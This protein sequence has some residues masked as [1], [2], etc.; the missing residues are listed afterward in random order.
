MAAPDT[1]A[2]DTLPKHAV[3]AAITSQFEAA[4]A[5]LEGCIDK[6]PDDR[7]DAQPPEAVAKYP[8]WQVAYHTL[9]FV[10]CYLSHGLDAFE[11]RTGPGGLH[12]AGEKELSDEYPSRRFERDE[13]TRYIAICREKLREAMAAETTESLAAPSGF[14]WLPF[15]RLEL[16][17]YNLRHLAHHTGQLTAYLRR[18]GVETKWVKDGTTPQ[19]R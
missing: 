8:F 15:S 18:F 14:S 3:A 5:M 12:P 1:S 9:C 17:L 11:Y 4:L 16:H 10:D 2:N 13:L 7:W 19:A 6:C